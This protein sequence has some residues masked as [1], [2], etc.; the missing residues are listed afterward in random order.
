MGEWSNVLPKSAQAR[1]S[2]QCLT[3]HTDVI[4]LVLCAVEDLEMNDGSPEKP[5]YMSKGLMGVLG[6]KNKEA[7]PEKG[8]KEDKKDKK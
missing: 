3:D 6:K 7:K 5:Y 8:G 4:M 1:K 2:H